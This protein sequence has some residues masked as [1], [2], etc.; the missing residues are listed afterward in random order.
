MNHPGKG[1][2]Y[3]ITIIIAALAVLVGTALAHERADHGYPVVFEDAA[4]HS[5][6]LKEKPR[7]VVSLSP[8]VT[9]IIFALGEQ[10]VLKGI[11]YHSTYPAEAGSKTIVGGFFH[12]S[13]SS[14]AALKP[15]VIFLSGLHKKVREHFRDVGVVMIEVDNRSM[16]DAYRTIELIGRIFNH[17]RK[18]DKIIAKI[19]AQIENVRKKVAK[20]PQS[21]R[22]RVIR[23]MGTKKIMT[24]GEDSF[25]ND[26]IRAAGGIPP[27]LGKHGPVVPMSKEE[28]QEFNPQ[29]VYYCGREWDLSKEYFDKPGWRDVDAV[30]NKN[31]VHFPCALTCRASVHMGDFI[32]GLAA[33]IYPL[34]FN[35]KKNNVC[36]E[37]LVRA[38][39]LKLDL[40]Y[41]K[42][43]RI[44]LSRIRDFMHQTL[45]IDFTEP[46]SVVSSLEG[47]VASIES[48]GN[49]HLP[50]PAW[51]L[52]H[53]LSLEDLKK[54]VCEVLQRQPHTTSLLFT[55]VAM[56]D[57]SVQK[58][59]YKDMVVYALVTAGVTGNAL[60][61]GTDTG[62]YYEIG[63]INIL[64]LTNMELTPRAMTR[65]IIAAT[66]GKTAA[67]QDLD[68]RS[69]PT[70]SVQATG[71]GTDN[72]IVVQG[73]GP[74]A[75]NA[76]GHTKL[77]ELVAKA[78]HA[79]VTHSIAKTN[80]I[81]AK[82]NVFTRM[83]ERNI[84]VFGIATRCMEL[85]ANDA[86]RMATDLEYLLL[87]P[88]YA[89]FIESAF[90][91]SS[92]YYSGLVSDLRPFE[93]LCRHTSEQ[94][95]GSE[96]KT[97]KRFIKPEAAPKVV[98][99]AFDALLNGLQNRPSK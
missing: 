52:G 97:P 65:S 18:A 82:R 70:P 60:R 10:D 89:S 74:R 94:I 48:I 2:P 93:D 79:G 90:A 96:I 38:R 44:L 72:I 6:V 33:S 50:Q 11:T 39:P 63:T 95:A 55:G 27:S 41:V 3:T 99:M 23:L 19:K 88:Q 66:E 67:L 22:K 54:T 77:G 16:E 71:T 53:T 37:E 91:L 47:C 80:G 75:R 5:I 62:N 69:R 58:Q 31:Y 8:T 86:A 98:R 51:N 35:D 9:D 29:L 45:L 78:V 92:A 49:H 21:K 14:I 42:S 64:I 26:F 24:P 32:S 73:R 7:R 1:L 4:H 13:P 59:Q 30:R 28:W 85:P 15:D 56:D 12:P 25:Q 87:K 43:A 34:E 76:G 17:K 57:L 68:I 61:A 36:K 84:D 40:N 20:I 83:R 81:V 46:M